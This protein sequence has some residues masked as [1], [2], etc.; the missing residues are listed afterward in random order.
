MTQISDI[1]VISKIIVISNN[2]LIIIDD[3]GCMY[4]QNQLDRDFDF[5]EHFTNLSDNSSIQDCL[6][7]MTLLPMEKG[8]IIE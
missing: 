1:G 7:D 6:K 4:H 2:E 3:R 8:T 5:I